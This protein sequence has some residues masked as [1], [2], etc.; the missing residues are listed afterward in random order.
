MRVG[1]K[2]ARVSAAEEVEVRECQ[3]KESLLKV[4]LMLV[5]LVAQEAASVAVVVAREVATPWV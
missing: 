2:S 4:S 1:V 5:E 3:E